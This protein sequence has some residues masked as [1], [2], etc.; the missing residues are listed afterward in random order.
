MK[1]GNDWHTETVWKLC[2]EM[3]NDAIH[4][5][6]KIGCL[7]SLKANFGFDMTKLIAPTAE[8]S[9]HEYISSKSV[10]TDEKMLYLRHKDG[11]VH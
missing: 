5:M 10:S 1:H 8:I 6:M 11:N 7:I 3:I 2:L 4:Q 9:A